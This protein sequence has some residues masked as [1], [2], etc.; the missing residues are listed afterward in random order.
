MKLIKLFSVIGLIYLFNACVSPEIQKQIDEIA[1]RQDSIVRVMKTMKDPLKRLGW[2]PPEDTI[3]IE[4]PLGKSYY[5]G[6]K[7]PVLTIVEFSDFQCHYC[8]GVAPILDSLVKTY[9][10]KIRVVF[11]HFPLGFHKQAMSAHAAALAAGKQGRFYDYRYK[12]APK[13][14]QLTDSTYLSLA[15]EMGLDM[16]AFKKEMALSPEVRARIDTDIKLGREIGV[17]GTPTV[18]ANGRK[19]KDRSFNGFVRL[20]KAAGG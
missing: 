13:F 20:L 5:Q 6:A 16:D 9:P 19:V 11:K 15:E 2:E 4:I 8:A 14:R 12:L 10:E 3:P 7:N 17:R 18:Y 1:A